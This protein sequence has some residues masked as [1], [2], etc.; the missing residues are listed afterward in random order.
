MK[1]EIN[2][3]IGFITGRPN[4]CKIINNYY[5]YLLEQVEELDTKVNFTIFILYDLTYQFTTRIDFYGVLPEVYKNINVKYITPE[6]ID[7]DK[8]KIISKYDI[9]KED[10][11]LLIGKGY[12]KARNTIL[13]YALKRNIDYLLFWD[14]DE[15]PLANVKDGKELE[16]IKQPDILEHLKHIENADATVGY[17]CGFM[18]PIPYIEYDDIITEN[19]YKKFI[20]GLENEVI[21]WEKAQQYRK[22]NT[23]MSYAERDIAE[24]TKKPEY[25]ENVGKTTF[26]LGSGICLNLR[27]LDKIPAF[28]NPPGARGED[29][30]FSCALGLKDAKVLR[31][32]TY[33]FHDCFLKFTG[34]MKDRYPKVLR[35]IALDD[36]GIEQRFLKTTIGWTKYK[37]LLYYITE[38]ENYKNIIAE[39]KKNLEESVPRINTAFETCDFSCLISELEDYDKNVKKHYKEYLKTTEI[40]D[41]LKYKI[42]QESK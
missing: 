5:K 17:R 19:D 12:A 37:P 39:T 7:E 9:S 10:A 11:E 16:W 6:D 8:K 42:S 20:D 35:R 13:Y 34:L 21:N 36:N 18:N 22:D 4:I 26:V 14:D 33:H 3:G 27:H 1:K 29:T 31:V 2:F 25:L 38:N 28:Y 40:W 23:C 24:H 32:P 41:N 30:F 15:Y